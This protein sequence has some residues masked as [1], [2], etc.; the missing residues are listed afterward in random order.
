MISSAKIISLQVIPRNE[1]EFKRIQRKHVTI[2]SV[3]HIELIRFSEIMFIQADGNYSH[4]RLSCGREVV[5]S[6]T[7]KT[8][9]QILESDNFVRPHASYIVNTDYIIKINKTKGWS[10]YL[11]NGMVPISRSRRKGFLREI[12]D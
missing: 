8:Y 7:L 5:S 11:L 6:K 1:S 10:I 12:C 3:N 9:Q 2:H 4:F